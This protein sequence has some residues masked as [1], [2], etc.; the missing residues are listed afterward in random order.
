[1]AVVVVVRDSVSE[2][3]RLD[4]YRTYHSRLILLSLF[5]PIVHY[6]YLEG[7]TVRDVESGEARA[8]VLVR[9]VLGIYIVCIL[10]D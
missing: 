10:L 6:S 9:L 3:S 1:M 7:G 8:L 5:W 2:L 4:V